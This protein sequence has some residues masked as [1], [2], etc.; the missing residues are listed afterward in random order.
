MTTARKYKLA[1]ISDQGSSSEGIKQSQ[2][3]FESMGV[4]G[5]RKFH[6]ITNQE[7]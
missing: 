6:L 7:H 1:R 2:I 3:L 4:L 5:A